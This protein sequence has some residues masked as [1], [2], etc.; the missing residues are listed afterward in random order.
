[1][2]EIEQ[3]PCPAKTFCLEQRHSTAFGT[4]IASQKQ[5]RTAPVF[6]SDAA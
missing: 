6:D 3:S 1:M 2:A 5:R 4:A